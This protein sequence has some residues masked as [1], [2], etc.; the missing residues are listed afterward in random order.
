MD[1]ALALAVS[2]PSDDVSYLDAKSSLSF[3]DQRFHIGIFKAIN[4]WFDQRRVEWNRRAAGFHPIKDRGYI[5]AI[6]TLMPNNSELVFEHYRFCCQRFTGDSWNRH[7]VLD[8]LGYFRKQ[9]FESKRDPAVLE[10]LYLGKDWRFTD[11][12]IDPSKLAACF[13]PLGSV[14]RIFRSRVII[15]LKRPI[16]FGSLHFTPA[17]GCTEHFFAALFDSSRFPYICLYLP[18]SIRDY[19]IEQAYSREKIHIPTNQVSMREWYLTAAAH[20]ANTVR[21]DGLTEDFSKGDYNVD[22]DATLKKFTD[23]ERS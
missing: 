19:D 9:Y 11:L 12:K 6:K 23:W 1:V 10:T 3:G 7:N 5:I 14:V 16:A 21:R 22:L 15:H 4:R 20:F 13:E 8:D 2:E 18:N 17:T